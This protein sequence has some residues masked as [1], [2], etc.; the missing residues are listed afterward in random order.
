M[1]LEAIMARARWLPLTLLVV[2]WLSPAGAAQENVPINRLGVD[3]VTLAD[4]QQVRGAV[5]SRQKEGGLVLAVERSWLEATLPEF[6]SQ[7]KEL[8]K[9]RLQKIREQLLPRLDAWIERREGNKELLL[10]LEEQRK[11]LSQPVDENQRRAVEPGFIFVELAE[12]GRA[13]V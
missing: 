7:Q 13:H 8:E 3:V 9:Q 6:Y 5:Y 11:R 12:I 4:G 1:R 10:Y 2:A